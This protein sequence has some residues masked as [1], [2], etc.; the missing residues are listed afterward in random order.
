MKTHRRKHFNAADKSLCSD[1]VTVLEKWVF[2]E[3]IRN[4]YEVAAMLHKN[5]CMAKSE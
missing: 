3:Q 1:S 4:E 5:S 2:S